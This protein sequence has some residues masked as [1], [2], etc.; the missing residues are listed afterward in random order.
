MTDYATGELQSTEE[1][2][3]QTSELHRTGKTSVK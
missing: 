1:T 3:Q 2:E